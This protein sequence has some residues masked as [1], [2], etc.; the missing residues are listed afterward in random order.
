MPTQQ[1]L[2]LRTWITDLDLA[3]RMDTAHQGSFHG[4]LRFSVA[5]A[6]RKQSVRAILQLSAHALWRA[7]WCCI[8]ATHKHG[9]A[10]APS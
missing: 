6:Y 2:I 5:H 10:Q 3:A 9:E 1:E 4:R 7:G 8:C